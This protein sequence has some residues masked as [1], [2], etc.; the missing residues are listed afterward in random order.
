MST[1]ELT[2]LG[3]TVM[4]IIV[5]WLLF[6]PRKIPHWLAYGLIAAVGVGVCVWVTPTIEAVFRENWRAGGAIVVSFLLAVRGAA[7][8]SKDAHIAPKTD[9]L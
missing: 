7:G 6:G 9:A 1:P 8:G 3:Q 5:Q 2:L 4:G